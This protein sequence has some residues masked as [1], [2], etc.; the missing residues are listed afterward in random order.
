MFGE[1]FSQKFNV[2]VVF[3]VEKILKE[4]GDVV[5]YIGKIVVCMEGM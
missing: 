1:L 3:R 2:F 5:L 4:I